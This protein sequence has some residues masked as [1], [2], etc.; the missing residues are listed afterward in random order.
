MDISAVRDQVVRDMDIS[1]V[2]DRVVRALKT[3]E[4]FSDVRA[5][6]AKAVLDEPGISSGSGR[7]N[8]DGKLYFLTIEQF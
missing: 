3:S 8:L 7:F 4:G 2:R 6:S 1:E 5:V